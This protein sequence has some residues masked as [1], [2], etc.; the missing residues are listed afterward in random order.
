L[1]PRW[2][3]CNPLDTNEKPGN[4][5]N[6]QQNQQQSELTD[7]KNIAF[8]DSQLS[9]LIQIFSQAN[10]NQREELLL[11]AEGLVRDRG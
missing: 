1:N 7:E 2:R 3:I 5:N 6:R 8:F 10:I 11:F 9:R 4:P